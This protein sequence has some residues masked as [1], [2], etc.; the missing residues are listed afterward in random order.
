MTNPKVV[1]DTPYGNPQGTLELG[2]YNAFRVET[3]NQVNWYLLNLT[4]R[5]PAWID[6]TGVEK[7]GNCSL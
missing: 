1:F 7:Q 4:D 6:G 2:A 3:V 5:P